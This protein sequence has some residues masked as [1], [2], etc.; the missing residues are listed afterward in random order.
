MVSNT[1]YIHVNG[2]RVQSD[3]DRLRVP[4]SIAK[5]YF[6]SPMTLSLS[7]KVLVGMYSLRQDVGVWM[8]LQA[9]FLVLGKFLQQ[10]YPENN[11]EM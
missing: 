9:P 5:F 1:S 10:V 6:K 4:L 2:H 7:L 11:K 8:L 3:T